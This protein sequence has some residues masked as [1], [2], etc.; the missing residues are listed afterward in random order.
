LLFCGWWQATCKYHSALPS[1]ICATLFLDEI[2]ELPL[3]LQP[4]LLRV[5]QDGEFER[6]GGTGTIK[7]DV[8]IVAA[9]NRNLE[10]EVAKG[11]FR[12]D[13]WYRLNVFTITMPPRG[14][15]TVICDH[16]F[17]MTLIPLPIASTRKSFFF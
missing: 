2:G 13:L 9:T 17:N 11:R 5:I 1:G 6:V 15:Q 7:V 16:R 14:P 4:K 12:E 3:E 8:R 10:Q